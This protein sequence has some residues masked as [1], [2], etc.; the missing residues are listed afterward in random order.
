ME[1]NGKIWLSSPMRVGP[2]MTACAP[3]VVRGPITTSGPITAK[4]PTR[5]P[6]PSCARGEITAR[7]SIKIWPP[8]LGHL[9]SHHHLRAGHFGRAD[10][11][12]AG[13]APDALEAA[14]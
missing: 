14:R 7:V 11:S 1:A 5:T 12:G 4:G 6:S 3:T 10:K 13:E 9:G 8:S 2:S